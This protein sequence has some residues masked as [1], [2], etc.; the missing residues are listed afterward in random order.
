MS[1]IGEQHITSILK[2]AHIQ[3]EAEKIFNNVP[4]IR[5]YRYDFYLPKQ[6]ILIEF[7]GRQHYEY[8]KFFHSKRSDFLKA[9]ERDR[10]KISYA[11]SKK[12]PL[13]II[14]FWELDNIHTSTDLFQKKFLALDKFHN[15][16]VW[17]NQ[18]N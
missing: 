12:I 6:N 8:N 2:D 13:Y 14:P 4:R 1:S 18:N 9:Q 16:K 17:R 11:L 10:R 7:N 15:D 3:F 5:Y